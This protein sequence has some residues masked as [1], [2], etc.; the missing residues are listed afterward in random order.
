MLRLSTMVGETEHPTSVL[1]ST[2]VLLNRVCIV[3]DVSVGWLFLWRVLPGAI[4][5]WYCTEGRC[6]RSSRA[7]VPALYTNAHSR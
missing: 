5:P 4:A 7:P 6:N 2:F 1:S 3:A